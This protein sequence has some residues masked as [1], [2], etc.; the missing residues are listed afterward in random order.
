MLIESVNASLAY[1]RVKEGLVTTVSF[2]AIEI[3]YKNGPNSLE[4][5]KPRKHYYMFYDDFPLFYW[6]LQT[7]IPNNDNHVSKQKSKRSP[8]ELTTL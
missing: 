7:H 5:P 6:N 1:L 3:H 2:W 4:H 8:A